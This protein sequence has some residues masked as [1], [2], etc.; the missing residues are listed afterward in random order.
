MADGIPSVEPPG[1]AV[2]R[3]ERKTVP[4]KLVL[5][6]PDESTAMTVTLKPALAVT[7]EAGVDTTSFV[8]VVTTTFKLAVADANGPAPLAAGAAA[9]NW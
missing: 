6:F 2:P 1:F 9:V 4:V 8:A 3:I 7:G 5:R